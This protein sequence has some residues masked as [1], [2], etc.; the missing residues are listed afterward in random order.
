MNRRLEPPFGDIWDGLRAGNVIPFL[1]AGASLAGRQPGLA[2]QASSSP[3]PPNGAELARYLAERC[4]FPAEEEQDDLA[5]VS[6][7]AADVSGRSLLR[8]RLRSVLNRP[9]PV[10]A[11]HKLLAELPSHLLVVVT[12]YDTLLEDAFRAAGKAFDLVVYPA[13]RPAWG[14]SLLWWANDKTEPVA[15]E[16]KELDLDLART[17]VIYKMHGTVWPAGEQWDN[18]VIT[19][20]DYVEFLSRMTTNTSSAV[21]AQF[22][23]YS[24]TRSFLF[25]GYSLRD[26]NLRVVL[27]N[28]RRQ[29]EA[30]TRGER[31]DEVPSWAIQWNPSPL[32]QKLWDRRN[33]SI[34]DMDLAEFA[35]RLTAV[36]S[37][38]ATQTGDAAAASVN[39][40]VLWQAD[41]RL[42]LAVTARRGPRFDFT[43]ED[44]VVDT[45]LDVVRAGRFKVPDVFGAGA[46][47]SPF[48]NLLLLVDYDRVRY[49]Q[50]K[51]DFI[52]IQAI[53]SGRQDQLRID[54]ANEWHAGAE[55]QVPNAFR[56]LAFRAGVWRDPDHAPRYV[57]TPRHDELDVLLGAALP[58]GETLTHVTAGGGIALSKYSNRLELNG[59]TDLSSRTRAAS[60]SAVVRF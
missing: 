56:A 52:D 15:I 9:Y 53:S 39:G 4:S 2:W 46:A 24:R 58:G 11:I 41:K 10:G 31:P 27:R 33:V 22:Y 51:T 13:E 55:Y 54:D 34:F 40:G 16:A 57:P 3:F 12:N 18:F 59:A 43:Q 47:F 45:G 25:L 49:G 20:E 36:Q 21:P 14:N 1:G 17:S 44:R 30:E 48:D 29:F 23:H 37:A 19:E 6:S 38:T 32:E 35:A 26:W 60:V 5:K 42:R 50:L 8:Q 28:L 7:Y